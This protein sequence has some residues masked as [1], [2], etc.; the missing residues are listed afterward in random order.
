MVLV[1]KS[2]ALFVIAGFCE[3]ALPP[4]SLASL[5]TPD[6]RRAN[7]QERLVR[8][9]NTLLHCSIARAISLGSSV[10]ERSREDAKVS[11]EPAELGDSPAKLRQLLADQGLQVGP[12]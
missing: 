12:G 11:L 5:G 7:L 10:G 8:Q 3:T 9:G 4:S 2:F 1:A 6:R